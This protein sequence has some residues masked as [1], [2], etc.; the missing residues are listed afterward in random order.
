MTDLEAPKQTLAELLRQLTEADE[1]VAVAMDPAQIIGDLR[2]K[3]DAIKS[4]IDRLK[5]QEEWC[6]QQAAPFMDAAHA[7]KTNR[8]RLNDYVAFTMRA[9]NFLELPGNAFR[10]KMQNN[11]ASLIITKITEADAQDFEKYPNYVR[12]VRYYE[13][14]KNA[15]KTALID[16][17]KTVQ[18]T[19]GEPRV[20]R[21]EFADPS[22]PMAKLTLGTHPRYYVSKPE[23]PPKEKK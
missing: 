13:F 22:I 23:L 11:P 9:N 21:A 12:M 19:E 5:F 4:V 20:P 15:I 7:C 3:V 6:R 8:E 10:I 1:A 16:K 14:D 17:L 18:E 2:S